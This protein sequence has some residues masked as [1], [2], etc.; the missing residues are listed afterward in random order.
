VQE[1]IE[2]H[3]RVFRHLHRFAH[4]ALEFLLLVHDF[5]RAA[6][7]YVGRAHH[8]RE[9]NFLCRAQ[10]LF[11]RTHD[12]VRRLLQLQALDHL[13]EAFA[14]FGTVDRVRAGT[15][16]R[17]A[18]GFEIARQFQRRLAAKLHDHAFRL[19][20]GDDFEHIFKRHRLE[21]EPVGGVVIGRHGL[22]V[23]ID[24]NGLV[25]V[26]AHSQ[27][28]VY[29]AV[30]EFD[31][32]AD[33]VRA[34][35]Q[36]QDL[37]AIA[38]VGFALFFVRGIHVGRAGREFR[39][40]GIDTLVD[41]AH[42]KLVA[43]AANFLLAYGQQHREALVGKTLALQ[44]PHIVGIDIGNRDRFQFGLG[45]HQ[46]FDL[47]QE[48]GID[49]GVLV[50]LFDAHAGAERIGHIP[51]TVRPRVLQFADHGIAGVVGIDIDLRF[52]TRRADLEPAQSF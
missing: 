37:V 47:H 52:E 27:R 5:H 4:V 41:R 17:Y 43:A 50:H 32:L 1:V 13:L 51:D 44:P 49:R 28:G 24:H 45:D 11:G 40:A 19:F 36:H 12:R 34:A 29:A 2:Q 22:R 20:L 42:A 46:I 35:T 15:D 8:Q 23:A 26:F 48:P 30:I 25:T 39:T 9:A 38:D 33:A 14:V 16:D 10:R 21:I 3:W 18:V 7:E 31:A 6:A